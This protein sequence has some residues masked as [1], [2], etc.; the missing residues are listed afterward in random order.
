VPDRVAKFRLSCQYLPELALASG[1]VS[2]QLAA[3]AFRLNPVPGL[4]P[5]FQW[6]WGCERVTVKYVNRERSTA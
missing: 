1:P 3:G 4:L 6:G 2:C 5:S